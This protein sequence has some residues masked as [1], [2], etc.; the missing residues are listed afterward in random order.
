MRA[1][2]DVVIVGSGA[3]GAVVARELARD[4]RSVLTL[5]EGGYYT[6]E[7]YGKLSPSQ[8]LRRL[9]RE[10]GLNHVYVGNVSD[11]G[12]SSSYC[13]CCGE[14]L[15]GRNGYT[16]TEWNLTA[17]GACPTCGTKMPG[18]IEAA[19]GQWGARRLPIRLAS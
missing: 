18:V 5:E 13:S 3:G 1:D 12:R 14:R 2:V 4:G 16:I 17:D 11:A 19:P 7:E 8:S 15:I 9:A 6:P 10:A